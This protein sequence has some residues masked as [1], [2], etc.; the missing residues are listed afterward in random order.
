MQEVWRPYEIF[1]GDRMTTLHKR[2]PVFSNYERKSEENKGKDYLI[3]HSAHLDRVKGLFSLLLVCIQT[4]E[5]K[6]FHIISSK[7]ATT[8]DTSCLV[9]KCNTMNH[10]HEQR[11]EWAS[12]RP[13]ACTHTR[14]KTDYR[15]SGIK[16]TSLP[17]EPLVLVLTLFNI[18]FTCATY[19]GSKRINMCVLPEGSVSR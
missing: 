2:A 14:K 13:H 3:S 11:S 8:V 16:D 17:R 19:G 1:I 4:P 15:Y 6:P 10:S 12:E 5:K 9:C 18:T 7:G